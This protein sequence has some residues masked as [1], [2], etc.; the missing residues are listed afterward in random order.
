M[1]MDEALLL[2]SRSSSGTGDRDSGQYLL[3]RGR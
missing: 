2:P 1:R 3:V